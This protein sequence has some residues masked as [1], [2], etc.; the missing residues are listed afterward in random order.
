MTNNEHSGDFQVTVGDIQGS[1][2]IVIGCG[3]SA[4]VNQPQSSAQEEV[5]AL[6]DDFIR[7]LG[8][9]IDSLDD[10]QGV[11]RSAETAR[12]EIA[13]PY[14]KWPA[15]RRL[16]TTIAASVAGVAALTDAISNMQA[17]VARIIG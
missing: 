11:Y 10:A 9:Y 16:L 15:V 5:G 12:A 14:P 8:I 13:R 2:G 6:L 7:S 3:S 1:S 4:A 17:I